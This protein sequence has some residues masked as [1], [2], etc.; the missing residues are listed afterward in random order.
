M[1]NTNAKHIFKQMPDVAFSHPDMD[2]S[3]TRVFMVV[4]DVAK[5]KGCAHHRN[6]TIA[7]LTGLS[8]R[9]VAR[10]LNKLERMGLL[11]RQG[12]SF[13]RKFTL[14]PLLK[15]STALYT[16][17]K[18]VKK[19]L[20]TYAKSSPK[21]RHS[22]IHTKSSPTNINSDIS[23]EDISLIRW[24]KSNPSVAVPKGLQHLFE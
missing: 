13:T 10:C 5:D 1:S 4:Y 14:G 16:K 8:E 20:S 7:R 3:C 24:Y 15:L 18:Q 22:G 23:L 21:H 19:N 12:M 6:Q 11:I 9:T 2:G 17:V